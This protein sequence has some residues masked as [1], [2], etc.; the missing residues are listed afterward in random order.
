VQDGR[1]LEKQLYYSVQ[2]ECLE[3]CETATPAAR[4]ILFC[5]ASLAQ[6]LGHELEDDA[7]EASAEPLWRAYPQELEQLVRL[8]A[9][10]K[11]AQET[12]WQ[13]SHAIGAIYPPQGRPS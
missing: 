7:I 9:S 2:R 1:S 11:S 13:V 12:L 10:P 6:A 8:A 4:V 3:A 5:A